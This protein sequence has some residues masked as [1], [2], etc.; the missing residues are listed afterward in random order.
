MNNNKD[1]LDQLFQ[2]A[3]TQAPKLS[4]EE[5]TMRFKASQAVMMTSGLE[6]SW[7]EKL[8]GNVNWLAGAAVAL[9][10]TTIIFTSLPTPPKGTENIVLEESVDSIVEDR[11]HL[12]EPKSWN[13]LSEQQQE[14][15]L[16]KR[17]KEHPNKATTNTSVIP[18]IEDSSINMDE[19]IN[20][21][22]KE[23]LNKDEEIIIQ[24][25]F[26][27]L[28]SLDLLSVKP[29]EQSTQPV[30]IDK[31]VQFKLTEFSTESDFDA[32]K[33]QAEAVG[34]DFHY[35]VHHQKKKKSK[36]VY[37]VRDFN[38]EMQ[39]PGTDIR[40]EIEVFVPRNGSFEVDLG[41]TLNEEGRAI[42]L[43]ESLKIDQTK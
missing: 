16:Y 10:G 41:W 26:P 8:I 14:P 17:S 12:P 21:G 11:I 15:Q 28:P 23:E 42:A 34:I 37:L 27:K 33:K 31:E 19:S 4:L 22:K 25:P 7:L 5:V 32:I 29:K 24:D 9:V 13:E 18:P 35:R 2:Q 39:I 30:A 36:N 43:S 1:Q 6:K 20:P 40:S 38:I 3:R